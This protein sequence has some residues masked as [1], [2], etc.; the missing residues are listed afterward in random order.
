MRIIK[1]KFHDPGKV[2]L[3]AQAVGSQEFTRMPY[4]IMSVDS[5]C[6]GGVQ[7]IF[8]ITCDRKPNT[9][10]SKR[11][12]IGSHPETSLALDMAG[13]RGLKNVT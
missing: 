4:L 5:S 9:N 12:F 8:L 13:S 11:K 1:G 10:L 6:D 7:Q 2:T 3:G